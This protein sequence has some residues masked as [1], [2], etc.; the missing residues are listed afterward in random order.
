ME[1]FGKKENLNIAFAVGDFLSEDE[2]YK[3][4]LDYGTV[5][6][7]YE[8]WDTDSD[9]LIPVKTRPCSS[10]DFQLDGATANPKFF[11]ASESKLGEFRRKMNLLK[12]PEEPLNLIGNFQTETA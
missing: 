7:Y 8:A 10:E 11:A 3:D 6:L 5:N 9:V 1:G 2:S 12:C 4:Y